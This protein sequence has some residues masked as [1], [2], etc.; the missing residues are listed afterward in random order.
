MWIWNGKKF[1]FFGKEVWGLDAVGYFNES[2]SCMC[3]GWND[4]LLFGI[5]LMDGISYVIS[6]GYLGESSAFFLN[7]KLEYES[8]YASY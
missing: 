5:S 3:V 1:I 6:A 4:W 2:V 7:I 8:Q